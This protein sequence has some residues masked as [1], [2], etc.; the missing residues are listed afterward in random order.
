[1]KHSKQVIAPDWD[2]RLLGLAALLCGIAL[3]PVAPTAALVG[4]AAV[5]LAVALFVGCVA[6]GILWLMLEMG[7]QKEEQEC[8]TEYEAELSKL[9]AEACRLREAWKSRLAIQQ[10]G[11]RRTYEAQDRAW[12]H[13]LLARQTEFNRQKEQWEA[14]LAQEQAHARRQ[15]DQAVRNWRTTMAARDAEVARQRKVWETNLAERQADALR[16]HEKEERN[17]KNSLTATQAEIQRQKQE[18]EAAMRT[19]Q[20]EARRVYE[21]AER[22]WN[23]TVAAMKAEAGRRR[24]KL[25]DL[26]IAL[27]Q[28]EQE[29]ATTAFRACEQFDAQKFALVRQKREY[30]NL[31]TQRSVELQQLLAATREAQFAAYLRGFLVEHHD[32]PDIGPGRKKKLADKGIRTAFDVASARIR[33]IHGFGEKLTHNLI[34]WRREIESRF[35]FKS[36]L[37]AAERA[38]LDA[39]YNPLLQPVEQQIEGGEKMLIRIAQ[40]AKRFVT[41]SYDRI[42][43]SMAQLAQAQA[44]VAVIPLYV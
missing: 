34:G 42:R 21:A 17:W 32:I 22:D 43:K 33:R 6:C 39:R 41:E 24:Q 18:W 36:A 35:V 1:M 31:E 13:A 26:R 30:D 37:P 15:Y 10:A 38:A 23:N 9:R 7:R 16:K 29:W 28:H 2:Q 14:T 40:D 27:S 19:K 25:H 8:N 11:A 44:D 4:G 20:A 12:K 3:F 5:F